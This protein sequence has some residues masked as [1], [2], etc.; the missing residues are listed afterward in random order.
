MNRHTDGCLL[1]ETLLNNLWKTLKVWSLNLWPHPR[2]WHL[3]IGKSEGL[4][5][6]NTSCYS[7]IWCYS[8]S[9]SVLFWR[10]RS[11]C[12]GRIAW[13]MTGIIGP[14][15]ISGK[16]PSASSASRVHPP[17][18]FL[19]RFDILSSAA[20][21]G[22]STPLRVHWKPWSVSSFPGQVRHLCFCSKT[23]DF[24]ATARTLVD[25]VYLVTLCARYILSSAAEHVTSSLLHR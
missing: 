17:R 10:R 1:T 3:D 6:G 7:E 20:E 12:G 23:R 21:H 13:K 5:T 15:S 9:R 18:C 14:V 4:A 2:W 19:D 8:S 11:I 24:L 16:L 22:T 25:L